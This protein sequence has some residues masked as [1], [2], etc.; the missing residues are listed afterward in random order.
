MFF[1]EKTIYF[2]NFVSII[3]V[4]VFIDLGFVLVNLWFLIF[5]VFFLFNPFF[6]HHIL[7]SRLPVDPVPDQ[8]QDF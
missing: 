3:Q 8:N 7:T 5:S 4:V 1:S 2:F 6:S